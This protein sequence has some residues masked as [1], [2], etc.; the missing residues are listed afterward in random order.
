MAQHYINQELG[1]VNIPMSHVMPWAIR[2]YIVLTMRHQTDQI[3]FRNNLL[4]QKI[5]ELI[6]QTVSGEHPSMSGDYFW[7]P[8]HRMPHF[9]PCPVCTEME[10]RFRHTG[11]SWEYLM[12]I[13]TDPMHKAIHK[14]SKVK[15]P[16]CYCTIVPKDEA[17]RIGVMTYGDQSRSPNN[18]AELSG[19]GR[20]LTPYLRDAIARV[21]RI[22]YVENFAFAEREVLRQMSSEVQ[23]F[24]A[25]PKSMAPITPLVASQGSTVR[26]GT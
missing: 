19:S 24:R 15:R 26:G 20:I 21:A 16:V 4:A 5:Q 8:E 22:H 1:S 3:F 12:N 10:E 18:D 14:R 11:A 13:M 17:N 2:R 6:N 23:S 25:R 9:G 7:V